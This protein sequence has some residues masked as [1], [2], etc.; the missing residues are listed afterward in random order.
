MNGYL[1]VSRLLR[2]WKN[3][4]PVKDYYQTHCREYFE[5]TFHVDPSFFLERF[6]RYLPSGSHILDVG[7]GSGRDLLW[8]KNKGFTV[9]GFERSLGLV[10]LARRNTGCPVIESDFEIFNFSALTVDAILMCGSLVH[11]SYDRFDKVLGK[12]IQALPQKKQ[13]PDSEY[14]L[15][16]IIYISLKEGKGALDDPDGRTFYLWQDSM[17]RALFDQ[18]G[19]VILDFLRSMSADGKGKSWLGYV[20]RVG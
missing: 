10:E 13:N 19:F 3:R 11:V 8:L 1:A 16:G 5:K 4:K 2:F 18:Q 20:L 17:L 14:Q 7:S 9:T 6:A 15:F 12:I